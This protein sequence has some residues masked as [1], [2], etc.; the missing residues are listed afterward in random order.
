MMTSIDPLMLWGHGR[1]PPPDHN[2]SWKLFKKLF[3]G[4]NFSN[5]QNEEHFSGL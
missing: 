3:Y 4:I 1:G 5:F 2:S